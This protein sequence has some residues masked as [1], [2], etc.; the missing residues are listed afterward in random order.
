MMNFELEIE[1]D[2][3]TWL[4]LD[5]TK[6]A[7]LKSIANE[8]SDI[9]LYALAALELRGDT[10][11]KRHP[12]DSYGGSS[13][14]FARPQEDKPNTIKRTEFN[15]YPNPSNNYIVLESNKRISE[16]CRVE[17][18]DIS[19]RLILNQQLDFRERNA[20]QI[21]LNGINSG[22]YFCRISDKEKQIE[23]IKFIHQ[24]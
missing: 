16:L 23:V 2:T 12:E 21:N 22:I 9:A 14:K 24:P 15:L 5:S 3:I 19:G 10:I 4:Q 17:I 6:V 20:N 1:E 8:D 13:G 7:L 11:I 18:F